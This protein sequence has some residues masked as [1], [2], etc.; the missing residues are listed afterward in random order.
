MQNKGL[1]NIHGYIIKSSD[2]SSGIAGKSS[3]DLYVYGGNP[4]DNLVD[5]TEQEDNSLTGN[6]KNWTLFNKTDKPLKQIEIEPFI[7]EKGEA[8][9]CEKSIITHNLDC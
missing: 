3:F 1:F 9:Y 4:G 7:K 2:E 6:E 5:F 8:K